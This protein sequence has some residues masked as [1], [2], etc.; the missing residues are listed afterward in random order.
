ML[1]N[2]CVN[3]RRY[4]QLLWLFCFIL[5]PLLAQAQNLEPPEVSVPNPDE[6]TASLAARAKAQNEELPA[7]K[8]F[9]QFHFADEV[10]ESGITFHHHPV[11][12]VL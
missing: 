2:P 9:H 10:I 3:S 4:F 5:T 12:D 1:Y 6:G 8:V 7:F 11:A